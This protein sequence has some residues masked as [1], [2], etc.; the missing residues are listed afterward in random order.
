VACVSELGFD[1]ASSWATA[2]LSSCS[3]MMLA[4]ICEPGNKS[5]G[6]DTA[7]NVLKIARS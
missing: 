1:E 5:A 3:D 6:G 4:D 2:S 7:I